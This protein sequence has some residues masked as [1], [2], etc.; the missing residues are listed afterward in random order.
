MK[1]YKMNST[2]KQIKKKNNNKKITMKR[3]IQMTI[4]KKIPIKIKSI[5]K[6]NKQ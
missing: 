4:T 1:K 5:F 3:N 6:K 2:N